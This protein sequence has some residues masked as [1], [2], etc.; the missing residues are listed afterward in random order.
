RSRSQP[1]DD[2]VAAARRLA[3][4]GYREVVLTGVNVGLYGQDRGAALVDLL[5]ALDEVDGIERYRISSV[6]PNLL[7]DAVVQFVAGARRFA[8]HFHLPLQSGDDFV[9]GRMR[10]RYRRGLYADRVAR[11][12]DLMPDAAI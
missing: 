5:R 1:V 11:I 9:L 4:E 7:T 2:V 6:E 8:P 3:D 10:R 12:R